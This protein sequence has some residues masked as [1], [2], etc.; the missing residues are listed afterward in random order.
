[1]ADVIIAMSNSHKFNMQSRYSKADIS[2][3]KEIAGMGS[4][5]VADPFGGSDEVYM[6]TANEI[7]EALNRFIN[8]N[9][10]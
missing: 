6:I 2:T 9:E 8:Q 5:D 7:K 1:M 4:G 10:T 3:L